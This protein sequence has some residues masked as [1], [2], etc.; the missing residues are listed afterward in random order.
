VK[1]SSLTIREI[2]GILILP[3]LIAV[4]FI[5][6]AS[7]TRAVTDAQLNVTCTSARAS[8]DQLTALREIADQLGVP[9][10]FTIPEVP[11]ECDG[12]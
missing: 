5:L 12:H 2:I 1:F 9:V 3:V 7:V 6:Y 8:V 10:T 4:G 11:P